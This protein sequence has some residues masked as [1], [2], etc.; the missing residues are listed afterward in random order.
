MLEVLELFAR[1]DETTRVTMTISSAVVIVAAVWA[2]AWAVVT[3]FR[4]APQML[5][6]LLPDQKKE[7]LPASPG[8]VLKKPPMSGMPVTALPLR[9]PYA[10]RDDARPCPHD[11]NLTNECLNPARDCLTRA[12]CDECVHIAG[13]HPEALRQFVDD[14][15]PPLRRVEQGSLASAAEFCDNVDR[16]KKAMRRQEGAM[17][18][19]AMPAV[20]AASMLDCGAGVGCDE[21]TGEDPLA[22]DM[23]MPL[24]AG[25]M[26]ITSGGPHGMPLMGNPC[27]SSTIRGPF[28][29]RLGS[30]HPQD[31]ELIDTMAEA[32]V[33]VNQRVSKLTARLDCVAEVLHQTL[34]LFEDVCRMTAAR[35]EA[36]QVVRAS[37]A[38][39]MM[40]RAPQQDD[41]VVVDVIGPCNAEEMAQVLQQ[42]GVPDELLADIFGIVRG[43]TTADVP[44]D[45][46][47]DC[48]SFRQMLDVLFAGMQMADM[49][50]A[51]QR[52]PRRTPDIASEVK[53][54][55]HLVNAISSALGI[56]LPAFGSAPPTQPPTQTPEEP[57]VLK[58]AP[59]NP[60]DCSHL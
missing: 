9:D 1:L 30:R 35:A 12:E 50:M 5:L 23:G 34:G 41:V 60:R 13:T 43:P 15:Q 8:E 3:V 31:Q 42:I 44:A 36:E 47:A 26:P 39:L 27:M 58:E 21:V 17:L 57:R 10:Q 56:P 4:R 29:G 19:A 33:E 16:R 32:I 49:Q 52:Q 48:V 37:A 40:P 24:M 2:L 38:P 45:D 14:R 28:R 55:N 7:E 54:V 59:A 11:D 22:E 53:K 51:E 25:G 6:H 46:D 18:S 20:H